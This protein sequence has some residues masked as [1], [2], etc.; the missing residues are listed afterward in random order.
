[1]LVRAVI[2]SAHRH[3]RTIVRLVEHQKCSSHFIHFPVLAA[4]HLAT[5]RLC[6]SAMQARSGLFIDRWTESSVYSLSLMLSIGY[7]LCQL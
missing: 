5:W 6:N 1:M 4:D 7:Q 2:R 3:L